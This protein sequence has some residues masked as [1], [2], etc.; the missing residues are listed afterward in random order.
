MNLKDIPEEFINFLLVTSFSLIIGL[1][2]R[3]L[4]PSNEE[5]K[6]F[7]TDRT[8]TFIG[9]LGFILCMV[10]PGEYWL[11]M[12][13]GFAILIF[14]AL[15]Y[16][17]RLV[18]MRIYGITTI[19]VAIITYCL[20]PL[21]I[22]QPRWLF[23]LVIVTVLIF[24]ELKESFG[25]ISK[26]FD[27]D[28]FITL[29][30]FLVIAGVILPI[31]PDEPFVEYLNI[32][33]YK[34]WL[35]VVVIS[36]ISYLSYLLKKFVFPK[37]G[38]LVSALLGGI[39]SSTATTLILSRKSKSSGKNQNQYAA[40]IILATA[41]MYVRILIILFIFNA[42]LFSILLPGF[43]ILILISF[44]VTYV[45]FRLK[46]EHVEEQ[47]R[48]IGYDKNPLEFKVALLFTVLYVL[49]TF[50][51]Y[52]VISNFGI[53]GLNILSLIVGVTDIDPFL[54]NLFQGRYDVGMNILAI[55]T[56]QAIISNNIV[57]ALY[58]HFLANKKILWTLLLGF[59]VI[60]IVNIIVTVFFYMS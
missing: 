52:Y 11:F 16:Y 24:T 34:V 35:A 14:L 19:I 29:G 33:P 18:N 12:G 5:F 31:F 9:I 4:H 20:A 6:P 1:A 40:G 50:I 55:A 37:S 60:I 17:M 22:T 56:L 15:Y 54:I 41:M 47:N 53:K 13:G 3:R 46:P 49:F 39:Y 48:H 38:I 25:V 28:E 10:T 23:L 8:F 7:G 26:K 36:S 32:T 58:S 57:K 45:I 27:K 59:S 51:T 42:A 30:K 21:V 43:A 2:Q 44:V